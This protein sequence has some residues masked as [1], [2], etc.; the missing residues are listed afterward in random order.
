MEN[1]LVLKIGEGISVRCHQWDG[2]KA[3]TCKLPGRVL[4]WNDELYLVVLGELTGWF[5]AD[6]IIVEEPFSIAMTMN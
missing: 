4:A 3:R 2:E 5:N 1:P 6:Q